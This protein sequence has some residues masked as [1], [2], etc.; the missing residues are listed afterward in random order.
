MCSVVFD[1]L[2]YLEWPS[3]CRN[4]QISID[5]EILPSD[6]FEGFLD[7]YLPL[8]LGSAWSC[9][10]KY[11]RK[12]ADNNLIEWLWFVWYNKLIIYQLNK[13]FNG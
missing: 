6:T 13:K 5:G 11:P 7:E 4:M 9:P 1:V 10:E 2:S 8:C 3:C 12:N